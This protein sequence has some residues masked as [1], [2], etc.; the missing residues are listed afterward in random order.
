[1]L[2]WSEYTFIV[3]MDFN[4]VWN[5]T[6]DKSGLTEINVCKKSASAAI[7]ALANSLGL[8]DL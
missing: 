1:M 8:A 5:A 6:V 3:G 2:E 4:A 7:R